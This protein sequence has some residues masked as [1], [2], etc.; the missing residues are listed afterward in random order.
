MS[1][2][3][4]YSE[5]VESLRRLCKDHKVQYSFLKKKL[6]EGRIS[7]DEYEYIVNGEEV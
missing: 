2:E 6:E 4:N 5:F 3:K 7:L 1:E